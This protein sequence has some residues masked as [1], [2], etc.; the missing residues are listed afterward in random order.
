M[1]AAC[2]LTKKPYSCNRCRKCFADGSNLSKHVRFSH[3]GEKSYACNKCCK[4]YLRNSDLKRHMRK[5]AGE[6]SRKCDSCGAEFSSEESLGA[7][8]CGK[9]K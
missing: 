3:T 8:Q 5:H 4:R 2:T 6:G 1:S 7:H 9:N